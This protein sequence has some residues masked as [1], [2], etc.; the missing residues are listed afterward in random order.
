MPVI[1]HAWQVFGGLNK[2]RKQKSELTFCLC[3]V[4]KQTPSWPLSWLSWPLFNQCLAV[5]MSNRTPS[6]MLPHHP[7]QWL[8]KKN[9]KK[10]PSKVLIFYYQS[11]GKWWVRQSSQLTGCSG[12]LDRSAWT[13]MKNIL[14]GLK[15]VSNHQTTATAK[16]SEV[17]RLA[18]HKLCWAIDGAAVWGRMAHRWEQSDWLTGHGACVGRLLW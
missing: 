5:L 6:G 14:S 2:N 7:S 13:E 17:Y 4:N 3:M 12:W 8:P 18:S 10:K 9:Q 16:D 15:N 11:E 1:C